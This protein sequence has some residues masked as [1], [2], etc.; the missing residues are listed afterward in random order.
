MKRI[1]SLFDYSGSWPE[2]FA[3]HG[4]DVWC[5]DIKD[6]NDV[7]QWG[8]CESLYSEVEYCDGVLAAVP[9][10]DFSSSGAR[11]WKQKDEDG[12]TEASVELCLQALRIVDAFIPTDLDEEHEF[13]W[14]IENPVGRIHKLIPE[15]GLPMYFDPCDFAGY[16]NLTSSDH[17]ELDR[18]RRKD[19]KGFCSEERQFVLDCNAYTKK[20]GIWGDFNRDMVKDRIEPVRCNPWGSPLMSLGGDNAKT[21]E[22]RSHTPVGFAKA[23]Y[24]ANKNHVA[25]L[26]CYDVMEAISKGEQLELVF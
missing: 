21:K 3:R 17:N 23:F 20:T 18:L 9:C 4:D 6:G 1:L 14:A 10:T 2:E 26:N 19:G 13:F 15:L 16:L 22:I 5:I 24:Q 25:E 12:R 11:W 8:D 7:N